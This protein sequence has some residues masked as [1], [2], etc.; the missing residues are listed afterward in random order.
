MLHNLDDISDL[1]EPEMEEFFQGQILDLDDILGI[2][3][4]GSGADFFGAEDLDID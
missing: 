4:K 2:L 3:G 1:T